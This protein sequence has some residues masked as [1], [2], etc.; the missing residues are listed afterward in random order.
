MAILVTGGA[1]YIGSHTVLAL[2]ER[3]E[4]VVVIDNLSNA[5]RISLQRVAELAGK[6]PVLYVA[7]ILDKAIFREV[8]TQHSITDVIHFAGLKSVSESIKEPLTY[9]ENNVT[10]TLVL[11][12]EMLEAG[13]NHLIF[14]SS[15][16]VY[17]NPDKIPLDEQ[18][19]TGGTTNPY[20]TSK[21]MV[22][23]ILADFSRAQPGFQVTCLRYFNPV[24]AHPSGRIGEDPNGIPNNLVPY[25]SQV[26]I[27]KLKMLSVF[28]SDYPTPD[29]TGVRDYIHVMDLA[30]GHLAAL[31][32]KEKGGT[33]KV[34]NLG[35]GIGY[36]VLDLV[37]AFEKMTGKKINYQLVGRRP[38]DVAECWSDPSLARQQIGWQATR[39]LDDM[40]RDTWNWQKNNPDGYRD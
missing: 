15:A 39:S 25:I 10:G 12:S 38:G 3:G 28:G 37:K 40:I 7:D 36:S 1:G 23:Q 30:S 5:S 16:T 4:D 22:E 13:V 26:A 2:L 9:Y 11:L 14:S 19:R 29:G 21:L 32:G 34:F 18:S 33:F 6:K 31:D 35:T 20:G 8:F 24:G 17:G 27:G